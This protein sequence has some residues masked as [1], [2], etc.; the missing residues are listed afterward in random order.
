[1]KVAGYWAA[2]CPLRMY[3]AYYVRQC[4]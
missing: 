4:L 2:L 1:M 3:A